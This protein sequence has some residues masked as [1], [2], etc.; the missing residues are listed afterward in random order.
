MFNF[1]RDYY[2]TFKRAIDIVG[3]VILLILLSPLMLIIAAAV[4]STSKGS[5]LFWSDRVAK[6]G[7]TFRMP[8]FRT[9]T[10]CSKVMS[11]ELAG[12]DDCKLTPIGA[13]LRKSS[14]DE[15]PQLWSIAC[16]H[17]SF[18]G[19]RPVL[20]FDDA[21]RLRKGYAELSAIR[22]GITGLAQIKGRNFV[23]PRN[24]ARYDAFYARE[25]CLFLDMKIV[26]KTIGILHRTELVK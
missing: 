26:F 12:Q 11:R 2:P 20:P 3:A 18:I 19:P 21:A 25:M 13:F 7:G 16:G 9:M 22:P 8:K 1:I 14:L 15:L 5:A 10:I 23:N 6:G 24:K 17:M 4:W